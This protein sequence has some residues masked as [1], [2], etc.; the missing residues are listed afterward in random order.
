[1]LLIVPHSG[2]P[3]MLPVT[4]VQSAPPFR[5]TCTSPSFVPTQMTP[6][7][8]GDSAIAELRAADLH[9]QVVLGQATGAGLP[10]LVV[11]RQIRADDLPSLA[12][13][14]RHVDVLAADVDAV[15]ACGEIAT[16]SIQFQR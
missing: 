3:G 1:M 2:I 7:S 4:L 9:A 8:R 12:A 5:V 11:E 14:R 10:A 6:A 13:V 15:M 16:G